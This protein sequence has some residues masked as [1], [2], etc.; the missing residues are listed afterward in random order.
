MSLCGEALE[1]FCKPFC[2][3]CFL[4]S[5]DLDLKLS[6]HCHICQLESYN[7]IDTSFFALILKSENCFLEPPEI[8]PFS[9]GDKTVNHGE[10][11]Q[12]ACFIKKGD[13]PVSITWSLKG[14]VISSDPSMSTTMLGSQTSI[15]T[16]DSVSYQHSGTYT[17]R[18]SNVAGTVTYSAQ[19]MVN[20]KQRDWRGTRESGPR[21]GHLRLFSTFL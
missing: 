11:A 13:K 6:F 19:L 7:P 5:L 9:F 20:G 8:V 16:I 4:G 21:A 2:T 1:T 14:D 17:C 3:F 18:A 10:S 15:L 12:I